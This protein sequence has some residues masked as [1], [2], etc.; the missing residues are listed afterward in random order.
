[1]PGNVVGQYI[2]RSLNRKTYTNGTTDSAVLDIQRVGTHTGGINGVV[3]NA[4]KIY[5]SALAGSTNYEWTAL[6]IMDNYCVGADNTENVAVYGQAI[7]RSTGPTWASVFEIRDVNTSAVAL[8]ASLG[9]E[10]SAVGSGNTLDTN[11]QRNGV[12]VA[13]LSDSLTGIAEWSRAFWTSTSAQARIRE[14]YSNTGAF[15]KAILRNSG[16]GTATATDTP[17]FIED[18][19][20]ASIGIDLSAATYSTNAA[21]KI[22][23]GDY[24][25][26]DAASV[27]GIRY[28]NNVIQLTGGR[29]RPTSGLDFVSGTAGLITNSA[30]PG[31]AT[32]PSNPSNFISIWIDGSPF[33]IPYYNA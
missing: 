15:S 1:L 3:T 32:L 28:F 7:K 6:T 27:T 29:V 11:Y 5:S 16:V 4:L 21:V 2:N 17:R 20:Q 23:S 33:K 13:V 25:H 24:I 22:K 12:N 14:C 10:I 18:V 19:G 8:G 30:T 31:I 26:L 9:I